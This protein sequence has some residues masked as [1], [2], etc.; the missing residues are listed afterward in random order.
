MRFPCMSRAIRHPSWSIVALALAIV[1]VGGC[2]ARSAAADDGHRRYHDGQRWL[3]VEVALDRFATGTAAG[4]PTAAHARGFITLAEPAA[5]VADLDVSAQE[6]RDRNPDTQVYACL[7]PPGADR[8]KT[9]AM[10]LTRRLTLRG[11]PGQDLAALAAKHGAQVVEK[12]G[13]SPDTVICEATG[14][15]LLAALDAANALREE[16]GVVFATP[17]IDRRFAQRAGR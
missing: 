15:S 6:Y 9:P 7:Y 5:F 16:P 3:E 2:A 4:S 8:D 13:Y 11:A 10:H 12:V 1:V 17:L 14:P